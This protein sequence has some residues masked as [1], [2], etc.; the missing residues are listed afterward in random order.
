MEND[1][2]NPTPVLKTTTDS[3][4]TCTVCFKHVTLATHKR[5]KSPNNL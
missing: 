4:L 3:W 2:A 1:I 5:K